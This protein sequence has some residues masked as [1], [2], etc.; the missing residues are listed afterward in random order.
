MSSHFGQSKDVSALVYV[1]EFESETAKA[2]AWEAFFAD[3]AWIN[4]WK[5]RSDPKDPM[6]TEV[7][8]EILFPAPFPS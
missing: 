7:S 2:A 5:E 1:C 8:S 6:V 4:A 3:S